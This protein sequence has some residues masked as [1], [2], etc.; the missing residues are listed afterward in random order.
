[1]TI[2]ES[3]DDVT[4]NTP[5][6]TVNVAV[7][8]ANVLAAPTSTV[9][10]QVE[11]GVTVYTILNCVNDFVEYN[12]DKNDVINLPQGTVDKQQTVT[13]RYVVS[14]SSINVHTITKVNIENVQKSAHFNSLSAT[15]VASNTNAID[16]T[17]TYTQQQLENISADFTMVVTFVD[18]KVTKIVKWDPVEK[19]LGIGA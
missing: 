18:N 11:N 15:Q 1:M 4:V 5:N 16:I 3:I 14:D 13:N 7:N 10:Q 19:D 17:A 6:Q 2:A 9:S 8:L 12:G